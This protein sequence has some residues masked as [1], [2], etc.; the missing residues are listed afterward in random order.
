MVRVAVVRY[1][2]GNVYSVA[3]ALRRAGA[4]PAIVEGRARL[5]EYD[6]V[7][8]PGVGSF[9]SAVRRLREWGL[10]EQLLDYVRAGGPL[11]GVCLGMQLLFEWSEE[12]GGAPGLGILPGRVERLRARKLPHMGWTRIRKVAACGLLEGVPDGSYMYF[13]HSYG[14]HA[15]GGFACAVASYGGSTFAAAVERPPVYGTQFHPE[16]SGRL[17]MSIVKAFV[18]R[19]RR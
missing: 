2:A 11:L 19:V 10:W 14:V 4:E 18:E 17:G 6:A 16:R 13:M 3:T 8:L 12:A 7:V 5:G 1:G 15:A 9:P